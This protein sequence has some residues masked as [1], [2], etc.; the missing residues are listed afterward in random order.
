M[1]E[2]E[3]KR[4]LAEHYKGLANR[5]ETSEQREHYDREFERAARAYNLA[6]IKERR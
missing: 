1:S 5:A 3:T 2:L 4:K 6:L